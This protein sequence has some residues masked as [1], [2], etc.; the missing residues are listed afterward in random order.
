[1]QCIPPVCK[2]IPRL[3]MQRPILETDRDGTNQLNGC[4]SSFLFSLLF[5]VSFFFF[6]LFAYL[7]VSLARVTP[8]LTPVSMAP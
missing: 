1:M 7:L 6:F 8:S 5:S 3:A 2:L 4:L